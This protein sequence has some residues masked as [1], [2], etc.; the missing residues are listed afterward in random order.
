MGFK[1]F[2]KIVKANL[3]SFMAYILILI[4][5]GLTFGLGG[6]TNTADFKI[7]A[8][9]YY[10]AITNENIG[11]LKEDSTLMFDYLR[12]NNL[13]R[14]ESDDPFSQGLFNYASNFVNVKN[15]IKVSEANDA[16][17]TGII[18]GVLIIP[19]NLSALTQ[20]NALFIFYTNSQDLANFTPTRAA[21]NK[22]INT[23]YDLKE[24]SEA[25]GESLTTAELTDK[26]SEALQKE[27]LIIY[28]NPNRSKMSM[29][30]QFFSF[31]TYIMSA[32][33]ILLV[34]I[35]MYEIKRQEILMR[36]AIT[37]Y[38]MSRLVVGLIF[39]A[40]T[41]SIAL[42]VLIYVLSIIIYPAI[43]LSVTGLYFMLNTMLFTLP[44]TA[45]AMVLG[46]V[47]QKAQVVSIL[48]TV[49]A[50]AQGF[51]SGAFVPAYLLPKGIINAGKIFPAAHTVTINNYIAEGASINTAG[52]LI[53]TGILV[54]YFT[55]LLVATILLSKKMTQREG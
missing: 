37:P 7:A 6:N 35:V 25:G 47:I 48:S 45:L 44:L 1:L 33:I 32:V 53:N 11:D 9:V 17:Y 34:S 50:I 19:E 10:A 43:A 22:F 24:T 31:S 8:T 40:I 12:D 49:F 41:M 5:T 52:I 15:D 26:V 55:V 16:I 29:L 20:E 42:T 30:S 13:M 38:S 3:A 21:L 23:Y 18:H 27:T 39:G 14:E 46:L 4:V 36:I 28:D 51:F 2:F 54:G